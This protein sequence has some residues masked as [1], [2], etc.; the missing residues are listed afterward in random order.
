MGP[1]TNCIR[2][3][4]FQWTSAAAMA[5]NIIKEK[6][7]SA[8]NLALPDFT[9]IFELHCDSS[10]TGIGTVLSQKGRPIAFFSEKISGAHFRYST[11]DIEFY[12]IV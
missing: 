4:S 5:F 9:T 1:L 7:S 10:K 8:P 2:E 6:L 3:G 11:N 12:A